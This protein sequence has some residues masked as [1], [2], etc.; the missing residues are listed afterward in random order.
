M[1]VAFP[2]LNVIEIAMISSLVSAADDAVLCVA[3][4]FKLGGVLH[5]TWNYKILCIFALLHP[6]TSLVRVIKEVYF[7]TQLSCDPNIYIGLETTKSV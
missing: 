7:T 4:H 5:M 2:D 3:K 1:I 6:R